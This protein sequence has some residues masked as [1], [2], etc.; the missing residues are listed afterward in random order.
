MRISTIIALGMTFLAT[1]PTTAASKSPL[2]L[3]HHAKSS[4]NLQTR[5]NAPET[6]MK[7]SEM[8]SKLKPGVTKTYGWNGKKWILDEEISYT[9][10]SAGNTITEKSLDAEGDYVSTVYEYDKNNK[11]IFKESKISSDGIYFENYKKTA[12][13]YDPILTN[14]ITKRT[15]WLWMNEDWRLVGNNY[16]R[17]ITRDDNGNITSVV[18]AVLFDGYYDP[19]DR[20]DITYGPDGKATTISEQILNYDGKEYY[21]E[22]GQKFTDIKWKD[23]DGQIYDPELLFLG[24]NR[25]LSAHYEDEDDFN[26]DV[27]VEYA[28]DSEAYKV[29]MQ[30]D[31]DGFIVSATMEYTPL[32]NNGYIAEGV[33]SYQ[34]QVLYSN[35]EE[36]R[37]DE[38]GHLLLAYEEEAEDDDI[39]FE[40]TV[41]SVE[42]DE[43]GLPI[44]YT[45]SEEYSD[46][47][48]M[49]V[50]EYAFR[51]E[52][53]NYIDV[54]AT[55]NDLK[56][57]Q[58]TPSV[59]YNLQ[60]LPVDN[61][62]KGSIIIKK[63]ANKASKI[64][65]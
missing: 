12:I 10:D 36:V 44:A 50:S 6:H 19:T 40:Q 15:E 21:W 62:T 60:G 3:L 47:P 25:L 30:M 43:A 59:Y 46:Y 31:M 52:Y 14:V 45:V 16:E 17:V 26:A 34:N 63:Q 64:I 27:Y 55:V 28:D 20:I 39:Y 32:E 7:I 56:V 5:R 35:K 24:N 41:G 2:H 22:Q 53:F 29:L 37:F 38:W 11:V 23:T 48:G 4:K 51:A 9:Y 57:D 54:T 58:D 1:F 18:I 49:L 42:F 8:A 33:T 13:E 65:F 61:P